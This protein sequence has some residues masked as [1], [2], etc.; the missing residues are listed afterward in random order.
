MLAGIALVTITLPACRTIPPDESTQADW[1]QSY[2]RRRDNLTQFANWSLEGRLAVSDGKEGG[3][4]HFNWVERAGSGRMDFHGTFGR[5][6]WQLVHDDRGAVLELADGSRYQANAINDLVRE[7]LGWEIPVDT[8]AWWVRG[9]AAPGG[10]EHRELNQ[11]G[12]LIVLQQRDWEIEF[13]RYRPFGIL[14]LPVKMTARQ[15]E[16]SVKLAIRN[17]SFGL[18]GGSNE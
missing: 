4:G 16:K 7:Q 14:Q 17:W 1:Q 13:G 9:L 10:I 18:D 3:S 5:G 2:E 8:L 12:Q 15:G 6:A 11:E